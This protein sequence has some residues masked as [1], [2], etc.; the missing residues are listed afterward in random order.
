M[1]VD[2]TQAATGLRWDCTE[3]IPKSALVCR[4]MSDFA[5]SALVWASDDLSRLLT[6]G[7]W[8]FQMHEY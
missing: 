2:P 6:Y 4:D 3:T 8:C 7:L 1:R 5:E